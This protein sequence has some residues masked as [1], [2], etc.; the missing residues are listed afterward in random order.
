MKCCNKSVRP[1]P[2]FLLAN[3]MFPRII[4]EIK[5]KKKQTPQAQT[6]MINSKLKMPRKGKIP[7][8]LCGPQFYRTISHTY[9]HKS[10]SGYTWVSPK[11]LSKT[12]NSPK[13]L[14][15]LRRHLL[16]NVRSPSSVHRELIPSGW[17]WRLSSQRNGPSIDL[18]PGYVGGLFG[19]ISC[20]FFLFF[21][22][23]QARPDGA[24]TTCHLG[25]WHPLRPA[26]KIFLPT[27]NA[28]AEPADERLT[29]LWRTAG[30]H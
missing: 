22:G 13:A 11:Y 20:F 17:A 25:M 24:V 9:V 21:F 27:W 4:Q 6:V 16:F 23:Q 2:G 29:D 3:G 15:I 10:P 18:D 30:I 12:S 28:P 1:G 8:L 5:E 26:H 14:T 19:F 7:H